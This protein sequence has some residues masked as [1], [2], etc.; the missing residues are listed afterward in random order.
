VEH[1]S[2]YLAVDYILGK[3]TKFWIKSLNYLK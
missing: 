3:I 2:K 1:K